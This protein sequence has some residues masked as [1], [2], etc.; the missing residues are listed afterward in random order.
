MVI[1]ARMLQVVTLWLAG[2]M[3]AVPALA[4]KA[5][6]AAPAFEL[7]AANGQ[8]VALADL[9]GRVVY[10]DFWA[11]W[12]APCR[13]SFPWMN[14][15][16]ARYAGEGLTIVGIN[17]DKRREDAERFLRDTPAAFTIA[18]DAQGTTPA[19]YAVAGMPSS[20]LVDRQGV[21]VDVEE[22]FHEARRAGVEARIRAA[23][24]QR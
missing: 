20:Y 22:G 23:L 24:A 21:I 11:S 9:R 3:L 18:Y 12:C 13:R 16:A 8:R 6:E 7:T 5:G 10:V 19:A 2:A 17:V 4:A 15:I 1:L 14:A